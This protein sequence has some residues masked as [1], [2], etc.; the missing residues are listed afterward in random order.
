[1]FLTEA[2][3]S[4]GIMLRFPDR[5]DIKITCPKC[6][7]ISLRNSTG[8]RKLCPHCLKIVRPKRAYASAAGHVVFGVLLSGILPPAGSLGIKKGID[9]LDELWC[10]E[11][12]RR[13]G[14]S[15][16]PK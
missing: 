6:R 5:P 13:I 16:D 10:P 15:G 2:C 14:K 8:E 1:M 3:G 7:T 9:A 4:C 12:G 11:C